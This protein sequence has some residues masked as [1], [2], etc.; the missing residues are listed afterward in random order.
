MKESQI[1]I[2]NKP[3]MA[4]DECVEKSE[5]PENDTLH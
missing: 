4:P 2:D 3:D 5:Q 1:A